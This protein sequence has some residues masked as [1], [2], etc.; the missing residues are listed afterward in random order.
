[1]R[2]SANDLSDVH[3]FAEIRRA[4]DVRFA[5]LHFS[6]VPYLFDHRLDDAVEPLERKLIE[7]GAIDATGCRY[8]G[9]LRG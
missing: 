4:V 5:E 7:A 3:T 1:V 6:W 2:E 9:E 8:V